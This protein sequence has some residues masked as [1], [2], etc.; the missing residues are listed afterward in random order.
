MPNL[1]PRGFNFASPNTMNALTRLIPRRGFSTSIPRCNLN[2]QA[3]NRSSKL[4]R[5]LLWGSV[6]GATLAG[7][8]AFSPKVHLDAAPKVEET[9]RPPLLVEDPPQSQILYFS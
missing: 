3:Y 1:D 7:Y 9:G 5:A 2:G 4:N 8:S 6:A